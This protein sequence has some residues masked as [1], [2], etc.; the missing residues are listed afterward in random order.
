MI[1]Y[2]TH[3]ICGTIVNSVSFHKVGRSCISIMNSINKAIKH[4][5]SLKVLNYSMFAAALVIS[6]LLSFA[7]HQT[8]E[9]YN[10]THTTTQNLFNLR[11]N[12]Y[13]LQRASDYLT[14]QIRCFVT[15]GDKQYLDNYFEEANVTQRRDK[16]LKELK[17]KS[18]DSVAFYNLKEAMKES[19][20]LMETEY[21]AARLAVEAYGYDLSDYPEEIQSVKLPSWTVSLSPEGKKIEAENALFGKE[22]Q[23]KKDSISSHMQNC[24]S[25]LESQMEQ[26]QQNVTYRLEQQVLYEHILTILLI[27]IMLAIVLLTAF[28]VISPLQKCVDLIRDEKDIPVKG[29]YEIRFL[30][31]TYNLMHHTNMEN[32]EKLTYEATHD[33]LTGLYNRRGYDFLIDNLD[34]ETSALLL[35][36]LDKFKSINDTYG[37]DI[38]DKILITVSDSIFKSFRAQDYI[39]RIGGDEMAVIMVHSDKA[40]SKLIRK[41]IKKINDK[42]SKGNEDDS[43]PPISISVGVAYGDDGITSEILFKH[44]DEALYRAKENGRHGICFYDEDAGTR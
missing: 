41:K 8:T 30:A 28:L 12:T 2:H 9:I 43:I 42:L 25:E 23:N 31:K 5:V 14:E 40:L 21:Y 44:A 33:K 39:C 17:N 1:Y 13:E 32:Q 11:K 29:A 3:L 15:S 37:H 24:L 36:D 38:G 18:G 22:Y 27:F 34:L 19:L 7:M 26:E 35:I 6:I 16:A 10:E 4:G 20:N